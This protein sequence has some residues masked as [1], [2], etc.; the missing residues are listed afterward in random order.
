MIKGVSGTLN[1]GV[2]ILSI[3]GSGTSTGTI[4]SGQNPSINIT[5]TSG[6]CPN[7]QSAFSGTLDSANDLITLS[8]PVDILDRNCVVFLTYASIILLSR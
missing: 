7:H 5:F 8:G 2:T 6:V 3:V 4:A 1:D